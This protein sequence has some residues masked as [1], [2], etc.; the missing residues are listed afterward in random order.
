MDG[1]DAHDVEDKYSHSLMYNINVY[2]LLFKSNILK[3]LLMMLI[4]FPTTA[5]IVPSAVAS[6]TFVM[7][8]M[9]VMTI[10]PYDFCIIEIKIIIVPTAS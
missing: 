1:Y 2:S 8:M 7:W 6:E 4:T 3:G 5:M 10:I 9:I